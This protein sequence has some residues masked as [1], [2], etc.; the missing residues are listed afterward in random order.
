MPEEQHL[1]LRERKKADTRK[2]LS[3]AALQLMFE[4]GLENVVR[5]DIAARAGVSVRTFNNYF[6]GK[7][8]ALAY[9]QLARIRGA[10]E[11]L[12][13]RPAH[14]PLWTAL[15]AAMVEPLEAE[16]SESGG[17]APTPEQLT[18]ARKLMAAPETR[19]ILS[20]G[21]EDDLIAA[22][23]ERTGTDPDR[24][25]YPRLVAGAAATAQQAAF[26][27]YVR[28]DPPVL[29]PPLL[30]Q[31]MAALAAGLPEPPA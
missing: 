17:R 11:I 2:A 4:R 10:I 31:A 22:I 30:R 12:R 13:S 15:T 6:S 24:D 9:R 26:E 21:F 29:L 7:H 8:E 3:D 28:A 5:E 18:E 27:I 19:A 25:M 1:G 20:K 14:E 23:A 16:L